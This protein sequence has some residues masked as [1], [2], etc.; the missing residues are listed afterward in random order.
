MKRLS[1]KPNVQAPDATWPFGKS[2][3]NTGSG[4]GF[5]LNSDTLEDYH[6]FFEKLFFESG[7]TANGLPDN[8]TN[9]FQLW[10]ALRVLVPMRTKIIQIGNWNMDSTPTVTI[11]HGLDYTKIRTASAY[12]LDDDN[13]VAAFL[14]GGEGSVASITSTTVDL[15]RNNAGFFDNASFNSGSINRGFLTIQ[16]VD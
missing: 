11:T 16:Y 3:D 6:Q 7:L 9:G 8:A 4:N 1:T 15:T 14:T 2:T 10:A 5:P 12:I 13:T